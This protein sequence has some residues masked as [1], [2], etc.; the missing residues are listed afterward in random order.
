[1]ILYDNAALVHIHGGH[2]PFLLDDRF[3]KVDTVTTVYSRGKFI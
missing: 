1:M 3:I 2:I